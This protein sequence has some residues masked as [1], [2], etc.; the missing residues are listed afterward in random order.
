MN[1]DTLQHRYEQRNKTRDL[2]R[3]RSKVLLEAQRERLI[4]EKFD[5]NT[6]KAVVNLVSRIKGIN[7]GGLTSLEQA[8]N[9]AVNDASRAL[10]GMGTGSLINRLKQLFGKGDP[11]ADPL[12]F[13][14]SMNTMFGDMK[15]FLGALG[16]TGQE[17]QTVEDAIAGEDGDPEKSKMLMKIISNG[18]KPTKGSSN[19][20]RRYLKK[21]LKSVAQEIASMQ[22][23][24]LLK[25][26]ETAADATKNAKAA[27]QA[28]AGAGQA[29]TKGTEP[30]SGTSPTSG[31]T[32]TGE[33]GESKPSKTTA[34][35][36]ETTKDTDADTEDNKKV[37][38]KVKKTYDDLVS[39]FGDVGND[40]QTVK[41]ILGTLTVL[42]NNGRLK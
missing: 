2:L 3:E 7:F 30:S 18:I 17:G 9:A 6:L 4:L 23:S 41:Q 13:A 10:A 38:A 37:K 32:S 14:A 20:V 24:D 15:E 42:A 39:D 26:A 21:N 33:T 5:R 12:S 27:Q 35:T 31:T 29:A 28:A 19:W 36:G 40:P 34:G 1:H 11:L 16:A 22:V 25:V 8:R